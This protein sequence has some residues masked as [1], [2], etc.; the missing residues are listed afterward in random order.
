M[1]LS[2][3]DLSDLFQAYGLESSGVSSG[4]IRELIE[5]LSSTKRTWSV[6]QEILE[7]NR[8]PITVM[9]IAYKAGMLIPMKRRYG[10]DAYRHFLENVKYYDLITDEVKSLDLYE[11]YLSIDPIKFLMR[12]RDSDLVQVGFIPGQD[13]EEALR[14]FYRNTL[15]V[16]GT[17]TLESNSRSTYSTKAKV[18]RYRS[19]YED[20]Y[21]SASDLTIL[22]DLSRGILWKDRQ[23]FG[24][25]RPELAFNRLALHQLR[26][27]ILEKFEQ[28]R[29]RDGFKQ[30]SGPPELHTILTGL[31][32]FLTNEPRNEISAYF[33]NPT[34]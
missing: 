22:F 27:R 2:R 18:I 13:R 28:W 10:L 4:Q 30:A 26:Q 17:F 5:H 9:K 25:P 24:D 11:I 32:N 15:E 14:K 21:Y 3:S 12:Y 7:S 6:L 23:G 16:Y 19:P 20:I 33:G 34:L 1:G 29:N 8:H 31:E